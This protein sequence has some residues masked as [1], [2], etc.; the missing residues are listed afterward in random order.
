MKKNNR[1]KNFFSILILGK[2]IHDFYPFRFFLTTNQK[3]LKIKKAII[4][5]YFELWFKLF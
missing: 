1:E 5:N 3:F 4:Q 2:I